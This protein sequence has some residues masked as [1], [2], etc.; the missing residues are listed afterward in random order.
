[1]E[2]NVERIQREARARR[3]EAK[4]ALRTDR[5]DHA[6]LAAQVQAGLAKDKEDTTIRRK[7]G[8]TVTPAKRRAL[9]ITRKPLARWGRRGGKSTSEVK[10]AAARLN[11][12][13]GGRPRRVDSVC[14]E[15]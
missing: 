9:E 8:L 10:A 5:I 7:G 12:T 14:F 3:E 4:V 13:K 1:M 15:N 2:T 6:Q 11:G